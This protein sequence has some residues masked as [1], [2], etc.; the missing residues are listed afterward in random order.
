MEATHREVRYVPDQDAPLSVVLV[1]QELL[2]QP[3]YLA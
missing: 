2:R 3:R 1:G